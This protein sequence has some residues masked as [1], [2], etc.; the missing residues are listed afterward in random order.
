MDVTK[1]ATGWGCLPILTAWQEDQLLRF[2]RL[3][4]S[5]AL[6]KS[7]STLIRKFTRGHAGEVLS[8]CYFTV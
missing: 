6:P 8:E 5:P 2:P 1:L 3:H 7:S 4:L